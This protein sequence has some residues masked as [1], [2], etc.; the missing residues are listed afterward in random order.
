MDQKKFVLNLMFF[1][2]LICFILIIFVDSGLWRLISQCCIN[3]VVNEDH[4][5]Y[6]DIDSDYELDDVEDKSVIVPAASL[7]V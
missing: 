6:E 2:H 4:E 7:L 5:W 1:S 3:C